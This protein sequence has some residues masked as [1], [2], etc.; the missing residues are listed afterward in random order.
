MTAFIEHLP[1]ILYTLV[2]FFLNLKFH[3]EAVIFEQTLTGLVTLIRHKVRSY[4]FLTQM[5]I[6]QRGRKTFQRRILSNN[7]V[8]YLLK[9]F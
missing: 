8:P 6:L 1:T 9:T 3:F 7:T 5:L 2:F 4:V